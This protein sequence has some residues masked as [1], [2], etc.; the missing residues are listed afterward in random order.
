MLIAGLLTLAVV[1]FVVKDHVRT[2]QSLRRVPGTNAF[3]MDCYV[4]YHIDEIRQRGMDVGHVQDSLIGTL[5]PNFVVP[6]ASR[7]KRA[8]I[9]AETKT[10]EAGGHHCSTMAIRSQNGHVYF[11]RNFD[12]HHDACLILRVHD[13]QGVASICVLDLA[14][15]N[16]NRSDLD[17]T[18]LVQRIPLLFAPYYLMDGMNRYGVAVADMSVDAQPPVDPG[19]PAIISSTLMRLILDRARDA[20]EAVKLVQE[21]NVHFVDVQEHLMVADAS[22][23]FRVI[24]FIDGKTVVTSPQGAWQVCTNHILAGKSERENDESCARYCTGSDLAES[25]GGAVDFAAALR[26]TKAMSVDG[27]TMW[28]SMYDLTSHEACIRYK[29]QGH[30]DYRDSIESH[31]QGR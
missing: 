26:I 23:R 9:P 10:I 25:L 28:S 19:K 31:N 14:Y 21:F 16:L 5:F 29:A 22:G 11:G 6:I 8:Y 1:A 13:A 4:D 12:W 27:Y 24:E 20:D 18:S 7:F 3:V 17:Q 15:L 2:L 30:N